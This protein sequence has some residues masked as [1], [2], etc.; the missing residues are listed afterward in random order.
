MLRLDSLAKDIRNGKFSFDEAAGFLSHDK[1]TR[2]NNGLMANPQTGTARFEM[3][4]LAKVSQEIAK[5][6]N[7]MNVGEISKPFVMV[8]R[9]GK[10]VCVIVKLKSRID[11]HKATIAEDYQRLKAIVEEKRSE[12]KL[13]KWIV[14]KQK[15]TYVRINEDWNKCEF[16]YPNWV[17]Q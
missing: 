15:T 16:K 1:D 17:I 14:Q 12:E 2:N 7:E 6:V 13:R 3:A 11:G 9:M 8:N 4:D 5:T 10:E